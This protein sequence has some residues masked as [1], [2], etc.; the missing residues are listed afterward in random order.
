MR[1]KSNDEINA[2]NLKQF[3][4]S[5]NVQ[6]KILSRKSSAIIIKQFTYGKE[7]RI[8]TK[9]F[10]TIENSAHFPGRLMAQTFS[11]QRTIGYNALGG[12]VNENEY[13][14]EVYRIMSPQH[15]NLLF[16]NAFFVESKDTHKLGFMIEQI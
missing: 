12:P 8:R 15:K 11:A 5:K 16:G 4:R 13:L 1:S 6:R 3:V 14:K 7:S 2:D 10:K 9:M